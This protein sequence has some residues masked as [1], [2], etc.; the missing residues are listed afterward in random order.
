MD[1]N[2]DSS[3]MSQSESNIMD[4]NQLMNILEK[5]KRVESELMKELQKEQS[6]EESRL[7]Y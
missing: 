4:D 1:F 5:R 3:S 7:H 2:E 6:R